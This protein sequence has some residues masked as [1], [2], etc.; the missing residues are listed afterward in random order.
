MN[1]EQ[2]LAKRIAESRM[3]E[4]DMLERVT[5]AL[6]LLDAET[7]NGDEDCSRVSTFEEDQIMTT[8]KGLVIRVGSNEFQVT[9]VRSR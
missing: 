7:P 6:D 4:Q 2:K 1:G 9:I 8:N 5:E 3:T